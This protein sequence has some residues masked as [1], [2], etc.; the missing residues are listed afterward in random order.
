MMQLEGL[1]T[2]KKIRRLHRDSNP[3]PSGLYHSVSTIYATTYRYIYKKVVQLLRTIRYFG[4]AF[5]F[6]SVQTLRVRVL[7]HLNVHFFRAPEFSLE[8][9]V[10]PFWYLF[11]AKRTRIQ[12]YGSHIVSTIGSQMAVRFSV[13]KPSLPN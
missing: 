11:D 10:T 2:M 13:L 12:S 5:M 1:D 9:T 6:N 7:C 3:R 4:N 8:L